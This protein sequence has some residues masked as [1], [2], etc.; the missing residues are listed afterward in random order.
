MGISYIFRA[1]K[2]EWPLGLSSITRRFALLTA[3][4]QHTLKS[5]KGETKTTRTL[6]RG[7][8]FAETLKPLRIMSE[9]FSLFSNDLQCFERFFRFSQ[10]YWLGD[11]NYRIT[12]LSNT[13]VKV[14]LQRNE[15]NALLKVDQ[16][17][18][19]RERGN[20]L[21]VSSS[22]N[23]CAQRSNRLFRTTQRATSPFNPPI[24]SI[25]LPMFTIP[26]KK[27]APLP[28]RIEYCGGVEASIS[29]TTGKKKTKFIEKYH[30]CIFCFRSHMDLKVSDHKPVSA[31]F[32][33]EISVVD[34]T[35][36]R[37]VHEDLLKKMDKHENEFLPQVTVDQ[38][39]VT[40]DLVK[41]REPQCR[42]III[43]NTGVVSR[44]IDFCINTFINGAHGSRLA[45][46][47]DL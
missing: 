38:T 47:V 32:K 12:D 5:T 18:Q 29:C 2:E 23:K 19:Q 3:I 1:T 20:V 42:D 35:K 15:M 43:A 10:V 4:W 46:A 33:S 6:M 39:E 7:S 9:Q 44:F 37:K 16:L 28:G 21:L 30:S 27:H 45:V 31:L 11:L 24:N 34:P 36:Y 41:F 25:Y 26:A 22:P 40:F 13:Q 8:I 17:N 14:L